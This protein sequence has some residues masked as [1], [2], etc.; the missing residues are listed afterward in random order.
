[1]KSLYNKWLAF[2]KNN[3][4]EQLKKEVSDLRVL[5]TASQGANTVAY[6]QLSSL[7]EQIK[8]SASGGFLGRRSLSRMGEE[9]SELLVRKTDPDWESKIATQMQV[10]WPAPN[11][12]SIDAATIGGLANFDAEKFSADLAAHIT[13]ASQNRTM[14]KE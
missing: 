1:M 12:L 2:W 3:E 8:P 5:L 10:A 7:V 6:Q 13:K 4:I 11:T 9:V 14:P